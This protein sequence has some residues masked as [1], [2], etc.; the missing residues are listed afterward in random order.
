MIYKRYIK[1]YKRF[2]E[3]D[4]ANEVAGFHKMDW[5]TGGEK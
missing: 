5:G 3:F 1:M 4:C 2:G